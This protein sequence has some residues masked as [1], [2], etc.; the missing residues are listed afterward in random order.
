MH[1][2][3]SECGGLIIGRPRAPVKC[4]TCGLVGIFV[5]KES[6]GTLENADVDPR[7]E[8]TRCG[9]RWAASHSRSQFLFGII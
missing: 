2:E 9:A 4:P 3:C 1:W 8:W 6:N 5:L 7:E